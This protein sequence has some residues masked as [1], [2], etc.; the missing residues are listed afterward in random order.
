MKAGVRTIALGCAVALAALAAVAVPA[1]AAGGGADAKRGSCGLTVS[2]QRGL[3]INGTY[4]TSVKSKGVKCKKAKKIVS[5]FHQCR[6]QNGG[7]DGNC[8]GDE[9]RALLRVVGDH[10]LGSGRFER[11]PDRAQVAGAVID[12]GKLRQVVVDT[13]KR[14]LEQLTGYRPVIVRVLAVRAVDRESR[15]RHPLSGR[16]EEQ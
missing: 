1:Q 15:K 12:E 14:P 3:G 8:G 11:S 13:G 16:L 10:D 9:H 2:E 5:K 4:V 7:R 6:K